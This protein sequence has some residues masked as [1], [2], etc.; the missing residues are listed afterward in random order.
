MR[1]STVCQR[2][3]R[4]CVRALA[5]RRAPCPAAP[6]QILMLK[7]ARSFYAEQYSSQQQ[8]R[9][10]T[11]STGLDYSTLST[12][13]GS[14]LHDQIMESAAMRQ[15][16]VSLKTLIDTGRGELLGGDIVFRESDLTTREQMLIQVASFLHRELPIRLAHRLAQQRSQHESACLQQLF[17]LLVIWSLIKQLM[18]AVYISHVWTG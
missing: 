6:S 13:P 12:P 11:S 8:Q 4:Q 18:S 14:P 9:G 15:T 17:L 5:R 3:A 2:A 16:G 7:P 10:L 1:A